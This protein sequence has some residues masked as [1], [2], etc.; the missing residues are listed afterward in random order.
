VS[1]IASQGARIAIDAVPVG[2]DPTDG[3]RVGELSDNVSDEILFLLWK[4]WKAA[5]S[6]SSV[7]Y[8]SLRRETDT[9]Q[10]AASDFLGT[11][12]NLR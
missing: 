3:V 10:L 11:F 6:T 9:R 1:G 4:N 12:R 7:T 8:R 2:G 5:F